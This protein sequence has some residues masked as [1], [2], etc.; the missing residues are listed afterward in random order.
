MFETLVADKLS[1]VGREVKMFKFPL[2]R[3]PG[4]IVLLDDSATL[5][6]SLVWRMPE[7]WAVK[8]FSDADEFLVWMK[9]KS[10]YRGNMREELSRRANLSKAGRSAL[11]E[12]I[13]YWDHYSERYELPNVVVVDF[14][15]PKT[16]GIDL[17][18]R[19][20]AFQGGR[21][22]L[23]AVADEKT[24][25]SAFNS[26][27][28]D[29]YVGKASN[30]MKDSL[31]PSIQGLFN[32]AAVADNLNWTP[33]LASLTVE[34]LM[35]LQSQELMHKL[36]EYVGEL[37]EYATL[38][39]PFGILSLPSE[40]THLNWLQLETKESVAEAAHLAKQAGATDDE[41]QAIAGGTAVSNARAVLELSPG[42]KVLVKPTMWKIDC[43]AIDNFVVAAD[44]EVTAPVVPYPETRYNAWRG[45]QPANQPDE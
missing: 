30:A 39:R 4:T 12:V 19:C 34:Q 38:G 3:S 6:P 29:R 1:I 27:K 23:S 2:A 24:A 14:H 45:R 18:D 25:T 41:V 26:N 37:G 44:F 42:A 17:L 22:L 15:M 16:N 43:R 20:A 10:D 36:L 7:S 8:T 35:L 40:V 11:F 31:L 5:L 28:I 32:K 21:L 33:W 9:A 13:R